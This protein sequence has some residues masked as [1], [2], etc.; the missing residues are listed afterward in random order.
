MSLPV[1]FGTG[2]WQQ[3]K[4]A[5]LELAGKEKNHVLVYE[6]HSES[7]VGNTEKRQGCSEAPSSLLTE[8]E[9]W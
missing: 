8:K 7:M 5:R 1:P 3:S 6:V 2:S 9:V 4:S